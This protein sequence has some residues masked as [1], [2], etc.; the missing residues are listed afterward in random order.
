MTIKCIA[1]P[2]NPTAKIFRLDDYP[3]VLDPSKGIIKFSNNHIANA[4]GSPAIAALFIRF[5]N[6]IR[7]VDIAATGKGNNKIDLVSV[8][9]K[10][11]KDWKTVP[12]E[13]IIEL[14]EER[15]QNHGTLIIVPDMKKAFDI[16]VDELRDA[17]RRY[18]PETVNK[19]NGDAAD[20]AIS[21]ADN[22]W[23]PETRQ[24]TCIFGEKCAEGGCGNISKLSTQH[25]LRSHL[26]ARYPEIRKVS[27]LDKAP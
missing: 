17:I 5:S 6:V 27:F 24:L 15:L 16:S 11:E 21:I 7:N 9:Y 19:D 8:T 26:L 22:G 10:S 3:S 12:P 4:I 23:N 18:R 1:H 14:L 2:N 20:K 13:D 25:T